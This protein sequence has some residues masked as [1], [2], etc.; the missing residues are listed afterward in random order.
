[1]NFLAKSFQSY[2][3][4]K[5]VITGGNGYIGS[6]LSASLSKSSIILEPW[7]INSHEIDKRNF[8]GDNNKF[9]LAFG[10][11][12]EINFQKGIAKLLLHELNNYDE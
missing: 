5:I 2:K 9:Y 10:W 1:M 7:P 3:N 11:K 8:V 4:K 12:P 6:S